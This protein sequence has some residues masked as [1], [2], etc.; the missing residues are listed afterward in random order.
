VRQHTAS[1]ERIRGEWR[2][3]KRTARNSGITLSGNHCDYA[4]KQA[5]RFVS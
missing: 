2:A 5:V 3:V 1:C 4:K